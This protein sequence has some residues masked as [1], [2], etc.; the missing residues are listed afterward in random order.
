MGESLGK[1]YDKNGARVEAGMVPTVSIGSTDLHSVGPII[2]RGPRIIYTTFVTIAQPS[3]TLLVPRSEP[4]HT[5]APEL[6]E[7]AVGDIMDAIVRGT[8]AAYAHEGRPYTV[9][10]L[11]DVSASSIGYLLQELHVW[12]CI[13]WISMNINPFDQP[14]VELYK[15]ET[16]K[17]LA[18]EWMYFYYFGSIRRPCKTQTIARNLSSGTSTQ[19]DNFIIVGAAIDDINARD[20]LDRA[21]P[22]MGTIDEKILETLCAA[23]LS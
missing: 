13:S 9:R 5:I 18:H 22:F 14:Q 15:Q 6:Q 19:I 7:R 17:I 23:L 20:M 3:A 10:Q 16:R 12:S 8:A 4:A 2:F 21:Q 11:S 1:A